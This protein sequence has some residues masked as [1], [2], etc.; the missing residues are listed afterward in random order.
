MRAHFDPP[1]L[2]CPAVNGLGKT[3]EVRRF[4]PVGHKALGNKGAQGLDL[5]L[6]FLAERRVDEE[7][8]ARGA[9]GFGQL[10][11]KL[12]D[13]NDA[14]AIELE[15]S[16]G[17]GDLGPQSIVPAQLV[18]ISDDEDFPRGGR[19]D[20]RALHVLDSSDNTRPSAARRVTWSGIWPA[21]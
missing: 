6:T 13:A 12:V 10:R 7:G 18:A 1:A 11:K 5:D 20:R 2:G 15:L 4:P 19:L 21:A 14:D 16:N 3:E 17:G 9:E 8:C